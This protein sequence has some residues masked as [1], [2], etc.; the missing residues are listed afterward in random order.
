MTDD[1]YHRCR[2]NKGCV[3]R[4]PDGSAVTAKPDTLC[5]GCVDDIQR[6]LGELPHLAQALQIFLG[7]SMAVTYTSRV[8]ST[9]T[10]QAPMNVAVYDLIDEIG[11]VIDRAGGTGMRVADLIRQPSAGFRI[12]SRGEIRDVYLDGVD[13]ALDIRRVHARA[14]G[15]V[16]LNRV[17][18]KRAAPC[19]ECHLPTLGTWIGTDTVSCANDDC[20][21]SFTITQ[22]EE[23]CIEQSREKR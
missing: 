16:G 8:N 2:A 11:D 14:D 21:S 9:P 4:T 15:M 22:Y 18:Q 12:W 10:P 7:G 13:R 1:A 5:A 3:S 19:P 6:R 17:W 20:D 23:L